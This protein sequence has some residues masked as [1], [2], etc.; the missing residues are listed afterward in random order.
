MFLESLS[1]DQDVGHIQDGNI[2]GNLSDGWNP[3]LDTTIC[4]EAI[5]DFLFQ[6][7]YTDGLEIATGSYASFSS[8]TEN[9]LLTPSLASTLSKDFDD[10]L[11]IKI[12]YLGQGTCDNIRGNNSMLSPCIHVETSIGTVTSGFL[13][14]VDTSFY[15]DIGVSLACNASNNSANSDCSASTSCNTSTKLRGRKR[16]A[17][18]SGIDGIEYDLLSKKDRKKLQNKCAAI[19]YR[20][21]KKEETN[22]KQSEIGQLEALNRSL[23]D[24]VNNLL[25][26]V[27]Y[28]KKLIIEILQ[29]KRKQS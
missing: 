2:A 16:A 28:I 17:A 6:D 27:D 10:C 18:F 24:Q 1:R 15:P 26:E 23:R 5:E 29:K 4:N 3:D 21:K 19:K 7:I 12:G 8:P 25:Y 22:S 13:D 11:D 20:S 14:T 9:D